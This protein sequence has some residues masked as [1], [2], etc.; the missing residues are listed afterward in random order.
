MPKALLCILHD[1]NSRF[2]YIQNYY[3]RLS[4]SVIVRLKKEEAKGW[5]LQTLTPIPKNTTIGYFVT[6]SSGAKER[7]AS[8]YCIQTNKN[9]GYIVT[10][11]ESLMNKVNTIVGITDKINCKLTCPR[12]GKV[13]IRTTKNIRAGSMLYMRYRC[14]D[15]VWKIQYEVLLQRLQKSGQKRVGSVISKNEDTCCRCRK[16]GYLYMCDNCIHSI[17]K[18]CLVKKERLSIHLTYFF[19]KTCL[20]SPKKYPNR[21]CKS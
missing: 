4:K 20:E 8:A 10:H 12:D 7:D 13:G 16:R 6:I 2:K 14:N 17:C 1:E 18:D 9:G 3:Y 19:C 15:H 21:F 11:K 5:G